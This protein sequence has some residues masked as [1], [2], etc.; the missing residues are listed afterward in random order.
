MSYLSWIRG[1]VGRQKILLVYASA[2]VRDDAGRVLWGRRGDFGWWGLPGGVLELDE[3]LAQ[4]A[5]REVREETGLAVEP[6]RLVGIYSSPD[7]D[8]TYPNGDQIQ[9]FSVCL[10]CRVSGWPLDAVRLRADGSETLEL[11]WFRPHYPPPTAPWYRAMLADALLGRPGASYRRGKPGSGRPAEPTFRQLR[12]FVGSAPLIVA[13]GV[14]FV[15]DDAGR[16]LLVLNRDS[17]Q[18]VLPGGAVELG[19]RVDQTVVHEV[20]EESGL[21]VRPTRLVGVYSGPDYGLRYPNGDQVQVASALFD[22]QLLGGT[23]RPDGDETLGAR[24][25]RPDALPEMPERFIR[26]LRD[27]LAGREA[28]IFV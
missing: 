10:E 16:V 22:C 12:R 7:Y 25:F 21:R 24:F 18:W 26:R 17:G 5:V 2:L 23:L 8:V 28:A 15:R 27:A 6:F 13:A 9:Q 19:E 14:G 20:W 1:H 4:C 11:G 3:T